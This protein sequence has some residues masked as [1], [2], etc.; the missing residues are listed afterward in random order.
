[1][2]PPPTRVCFET[3]VLWGAFHSPAGPNFR[4]LELA[5]QRTPV[6]DG[7]F[8]DAVGAEFWWRATQQGV[9]GPGQSIPRT[10]SEAELTPFFETF[11]VL[12]EPS[13]IPRAPLSRSLGRY[14]G[15]V[16]MPLGEVLAEITGKDRDALIAGMTIAF[17]MTFETIDTAD[18]HVIAGAIGN[19][20]D[21]LISNDRRTLA[22]SPIGSMPVRTAR[23][24]AEDLGL[25]APTTT[26]VR[27]RP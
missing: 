21:E 24:L 9:A 4:L 8:T 27:Q 20:A 19:D 1:M 25:I 23:A 14:A 22:L 18:L 3:T 7:F 15:M 26:S 13:Q 10:Y 11:D 17:P 6:L 5:A 2:S 16:G 12:F